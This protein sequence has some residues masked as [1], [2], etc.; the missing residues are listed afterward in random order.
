MIKDKDKFIEYLEQRCRELWEENEKL[1]FKNFC[2][3]IR[4]KKGIINKTENSLVPKDEF[5]QIYSGSYCIGEFDTR[6]GYIFISDNNLEIHI[7]EIK[8]IIK[9]IEETL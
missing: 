2:Q 3:S 6:S 4:D 1:K 5:F 7:D 9:L 8:N